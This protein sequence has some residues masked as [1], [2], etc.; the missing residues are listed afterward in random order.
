MF[1]K[2][3]ASIDA[4]WNKFVNFAKGVKTFVLAAFAT[5]AGIITTFDP[6]LITNV[7]DTDFKRGVA[8]LIFGILVAL[9]RLATRHANQPTE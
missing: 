3:K 8:M 9:A 5:F 4:I 1:K 7:L 6:T 2:L